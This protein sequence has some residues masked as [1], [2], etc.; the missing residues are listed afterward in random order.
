MPLIHRG[1]TGRKISDGEAC[2]RR[3]RRPQP[4]S[5]NVGKKSCRNEETGCVGSVTEGPETDVPV[6]SPELERGR[7][8]QSGKVCI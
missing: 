2:R 7:Q 6:T 5:L 4:G 3:K 8:K 1:Q